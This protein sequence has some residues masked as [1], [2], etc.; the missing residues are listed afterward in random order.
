M[1]IDE[2]RTPLIISG[3]V[4]NESDAQYFEHNAAV[5]RLVRKQTELVNVL[6]ADGGAAARGGRHAATPRSSSIRRSSAIRRTG[7]CSS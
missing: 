7:G 2:A 6:V 3:P 5:A 1:L 4:G